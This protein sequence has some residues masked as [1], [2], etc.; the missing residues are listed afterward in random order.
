MSVLENY[1]VSKSVAALREVAISSASIEDRRVVR[2]ISKA[3]CGPL[4]SEETTRNGITI[5]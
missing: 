1:L 2:S 3:S 4:F 5:V